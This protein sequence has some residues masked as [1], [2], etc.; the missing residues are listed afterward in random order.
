M[1]LNPAAG[2]LT[3][4]KRRLAAGVVTDVVI[5]NGRGGS[6]WG[7]A[8]GSDAAATAAAN[9]PSGAANGASTSS[10]IIRATEPEGRVHC[11]AKWPRARRGKTKC[12]A[13]SRLGAYASKQAIR[14]ASLDG[15]GALYRKLDQFTMQALCCSASFVME[16]RCSSAMHAPSA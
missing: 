2:G 6:S 16:R 8:I 9:S 5:W 1:L 15:A 14:Q 13:G 10:T 7:L 12:T 11:E 3:T 4:R